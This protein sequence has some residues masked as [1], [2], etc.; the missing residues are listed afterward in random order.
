MGFNCTRTL[1]H[2]LTTKHR[3]LF[4]P[5]STIA[6]F[7][8]EV[9]EKKIQDYVRSG[10]TKSPVWVFFLKLGA[11]R[12]QCQLCGRILFCKLGS[13]TAMKNHVLGLHNF[14][15]KYDAAKRMKDLQELKDERQRNLRKTDYRDYLA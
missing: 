11:N 9:F 15:T 5:S 8:A 10:S 4:P 14:K 1:T 2:S 3:L 13:T 12:C 7:D 6:P